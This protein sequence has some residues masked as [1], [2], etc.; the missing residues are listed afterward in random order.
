MNHAALSVA[1]VADAP[2]LSQSPQLLTVRGTAQRLEPAIS[3]TTIRD[4]IY[5]AEP[6]INA[7]GETIKSEWFRRLPDPNRRQARQAIDRLGPFP[8]MD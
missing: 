6:R 7:R 8:R 5:H 3:E 2:A 4:W 1:D